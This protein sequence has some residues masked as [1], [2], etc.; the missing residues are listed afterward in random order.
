MKQNIQ[1]RDNWRTGLYHTA[2]TPGLEI[3]TP[4]WKTEKG[5]KQN[6]ARLSG[7]T[8]PPVVINVSDH[9]I[10]HRGTLSVNVGEVVFSK[11][12]TDRLKAGHYRELLHSGRLV[13]IGA[14]TGKSSYEM[15]GDITSPGDSVA[16][17]EYVLNQ[18]A[19]A[20]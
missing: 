17:Y 13:I 3:I 15:A 14:L 4:G 16:I 20:K 5:R 11:D 6:R 7:I 9:S 1:Q 10:T 12:I 2:I 18:A 8:L 19:A